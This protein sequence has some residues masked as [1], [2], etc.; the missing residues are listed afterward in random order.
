MASTGAPPP[1]PPEPTIPIENGRQIAMIVTSTLAIIVPTALVG[2]R[3]WAGRIANRRLDA[4][5]ACIFAALVFTIGLHVDM[6]VMV[7]LGGFGF[8]VVDIIQRFGMDT[9][10]LFLKGIL[11]FPIIWNFTI[12]FSKLS[13]LFMYASVI[14]AQA[15]ITSCRVVGLFIILWN[16]GGILGALLLCRPF[17]F[18]WDKTMSG[19]CGDQRLFYIWLGGINVVVEAVILLM[20][21][22]FI[23]G[24]QMETFKKLVVIGLFSVGWMTCA[25]TIYRQATLPHLYFEDMTYT[26]VLA[27]IFTGIEPSV[28]LSLAC[29]PF[30]RPLTR[31]HRRQQQQHGKAGAG[32]STGSDGSQ[33]GGSTLR[34]GGG[35][36]KAPPS[37]LGGN[38]APFKELTD[39]SSEI[40]LQPLGSDQLK[41]E[42]EVSRQERE[43]EEH[44]DDEER[45][46][47]RGPQTSGELTAGAIVVKKSWNVVPGTR[48]GS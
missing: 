13:V 12:C 25:V 20:P 23:Y 32:H 27:T 48:P 1:G 33:Y 36:S 44:D 21:V 28:A 46:K 26:G 47:G 9:L 45:E 35:K 17:A 15:M 31:A 40:Q 37:G 19:T 34:S 16:T 30:L 42:A 3:F 4:S 22:P 18:N 8:H 6:Y 29:V 43:E 7:L 41:Y 24:L 38:R 14:P 5:D 11:A 39:D 10:V 2:L